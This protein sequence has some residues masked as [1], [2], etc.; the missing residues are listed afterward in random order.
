LDCQTAAL[1]FAPECPLLA[2]SVEKL[3]WQFGRDD[4]S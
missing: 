3:S 2:D 1:P 4:L